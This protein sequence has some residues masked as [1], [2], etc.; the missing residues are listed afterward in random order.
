M[1]GPTAVTTWVCP[2]RACNARIEVRQYG[3]NP[4]KHTPAVDHYC[5]GKIGSPLVA[6]I[7]VLK[8]QA[9]ESLGDPP[10]TATV[11]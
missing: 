2:T 4:E 5:R 8:T 9:D 7:R 6:M 3:S 11:D 10:K 1:S